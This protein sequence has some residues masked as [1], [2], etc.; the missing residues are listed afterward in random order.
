[1]TAAHDVSR[2]T[3]VVLDATAFA[4]AI[5]DLGEILVDAV[6]S[7]ASV[8]FVLPFS[9]ADG[10]AWW[11]SRQHDVASGTIRPIVARI[12][13]RIEGVSLLVLSRKPNSPHRAE[14]QKVLVHRRARRHG[15]GTGLMDAVEDLARSE[16]RWLLILDTF[17]GSDAERL[18]RRLG[19]IEVGVIPDHSLLTDGVLAPATIFRKDLRDAEVR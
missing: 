7:G 9:V 11:R 13:G 4:A 2:V 1:M 10:V 19:W 14:V 18:Y 8:N 15:L 3:Y 12:D 6:D 5:D 17:S 16:G